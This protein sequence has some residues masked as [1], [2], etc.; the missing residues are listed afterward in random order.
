MPLGGTCWPFDRG[1]SA[2]AGALLSTC[3]ANAFHNERPRHPRTG[4]ETRSMNH[5]YPLFPF[6]PWGQAGAGSQALKYAPP[7][8][9]YWKRNLHRGLRGRYLDAYA[10]RGRLPAT[11]ARRPAQA[12]SAGTNRGCVRAHQVGR[13][14]VIDKEVQKLDAGSLWPFTNGT[15]VVG[16]TTRFAWAAVTRRPTLRAREK[17]QAA[18]EQ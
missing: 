18:S 6:A 3:P 5:S 16:S 9:S 7:I 2:S 14:P 1:T 4:C 12:Q 15:R 8:T 17:Y 11:P 10:G 13:L